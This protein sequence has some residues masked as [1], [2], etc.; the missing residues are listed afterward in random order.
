MPRGWRVRGL[1]AGVSILSVLGLAALPPE[2]LHARPAHD[3]RR[4]DLVH[5]HFAAHHA[6]DRGLHVEGDDSAPRWLDSSYVSGERVSAVHRSDASVGLVVP[7]PAPRA[8]SATTA[9]PES[10]SVHDPPPGA[11]FGLRAPPFLS[12]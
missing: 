8:A 7:T 10:M 12:L 5:R 1:I 4:S 11:S 9:R 2:H 3:G 6:A